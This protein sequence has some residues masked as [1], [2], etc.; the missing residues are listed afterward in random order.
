MTGATILDRLKAAAEKAR[1][2]FNT[3]TL[4]DTLSNR[5]LEHI[6]A[7]IAKE[8]AETGDKA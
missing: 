8:E 3:W 5:T 6:R 1:D 7:V 4:P 2:D